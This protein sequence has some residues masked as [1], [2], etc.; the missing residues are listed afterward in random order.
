MITCFQLMITFGLLM[1]YLGDAV[2][3]LLPDSVSWRCMLGV[4]G[5]PALFQFFGFLFMPESP[6]WLVSHD[7]VHFPSSPPPF[8]G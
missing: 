4:A 3:A 7:R 2:F 1:S 6:R 8:P 5:V